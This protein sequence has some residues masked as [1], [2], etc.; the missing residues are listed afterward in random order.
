M[1]RILNIITKKAF[2]SLFIFLVEI[3]ILIIFVIALEKNFM[4]FW[5]INYILNIITAFSIVNSNLSNAFKLTWVIGLILLPGIGT[6]LFFVFGRKPTT[7]KMKRVFQQTKINQNSILNFKS[8]FEQS[9]INPAYLQIMSWIWNISSQPTYDNTETK[10]FNSGESYFDSLITDLKAAKKSIFLE[11]FIICSGYVWNRI[12]EILEDKAAQGL[13]VRLIYDD[14]GSFINLPKNYDQKLNKLKIKTK[15]FNKIKLR[16]NSFMNN[17]DH[18]KIVIID[19]IIS[20]TGGINLADEYVNKIKRFGHWQDSAIR[21]KGPATQSFTNLFLNM[22]CY[23]TNKPIEPNQSSQKELISLDNGLVLPFGDS[24]INK[25]R[26]HYTLY[27][28]IIN[29]AKKYVYIQTPYLVLDEHLTNA[30]SCCAQSGVKVIIIT[31][32]IFDKV[33]VRTV[34]Q[35][36]YQNLINSGV[37]IFEYTPGFMHSKILISDDEVAVIGTA[38]FDYRSLYM[39]FENSVLLYKTKAVVDMVKNFKDLLNKCEKITLEVYKKKSLINKIL[40]IFLKP[41]ATFL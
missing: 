14:F 28:K 29:C 20:Y 13:D 41:F 9:S 22:W 34:T 24:P 40:N 19:N 27:L 26:L 4:T 17:R 25:N 35:S 38:N 18:R 33:Y 11:F 10:F 36:T 23:L 37:E 1:N 31:P 30:L 12:V 15:I 2:I 39:Q 6:V 21:I 7:K 8:K 3:L 16:I 32:H 5:L